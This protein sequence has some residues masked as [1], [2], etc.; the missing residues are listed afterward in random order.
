MLHAPDSRELLNRL[1]YLCTKINKFFRNSVI[2]KQL[3]INLQKRT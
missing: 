3:F 2:Q 1:I